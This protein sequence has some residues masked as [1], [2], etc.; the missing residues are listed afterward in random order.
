MNR[1]A[2][3]CIHKE[4]R[5]AAVHRCCQARNRTL[6]DCK[7]LKI[8]DWEAAGIAAENYL[9]ALPDIASIQDIKDYAACINHAVAISVLQPSDGNAMLA[10]A[11]IVMQTV[12]AE[13]AH[14]LST[15][16]IEHANAKIALAQSREDRQKA[17][18]KLREE[19][20]PAA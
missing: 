14:R 15:A 1:H 2:R 3:P 19:A 8:A 6:A 17:K 5:N 10:T 20:H 16:R 7:G 11:R 9:A 18:L 12:R 13:E 4:T